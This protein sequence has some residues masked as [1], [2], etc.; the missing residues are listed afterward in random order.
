MN[1]FTF[2]VTRWVTFV[3]APLLLV[4]TTF[5]ATKAKAWFGV[6]L[7]TG[8]IVALLL[9]LVAPIVAWLIG[10]IRWELALH[11][12]QTTE[13]EIDRI[14]QRALELLPPPPAAP[15]PGAGSQQPPRA[16]GS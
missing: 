5:V 3:I 12:G 15:A 2:Y 8:E 9:S 4:G 6:E 10:R 1:S 7:D 11:F 13:N 14:A 16:P